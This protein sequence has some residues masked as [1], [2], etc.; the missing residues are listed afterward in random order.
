M[1]SSPDETR[2]QVLEPS[3][4]DLD[5]DNCIAK[6]QGD[7]GGQEAEGSNEEAKHKDKEGVEGEEQGLDDETSER[8]KVSGDSAL[9][10]SKT[11][12]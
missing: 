8:W 9:P 12:G 3:G 1:A 4:I 10:A 11:N 7:G 2:K 5:P 6:L